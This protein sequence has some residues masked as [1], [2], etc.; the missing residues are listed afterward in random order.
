MYFNDKKYKTFLV[1]L[2]GKYKTFLLAESKEHVENK[3][4]SLYV[5]NNIEC[6][7]EPKIEEIPQINDVLRSL[8]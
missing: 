8:K 3:V 7:K 6:K 4:A 5:K 2:E 1:T